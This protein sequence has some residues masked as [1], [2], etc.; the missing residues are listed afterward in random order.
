[1]SDDHLTIGICQGGPLDGQQVSVRSAGFLAVDRQAGK[2]WR[3]QPDSTG[4]VVCTDH[5]DS[6]IYPQGTTTGERAYDPDR[7]W[8]AGEAMDLDI[9]AV[10]PS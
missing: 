10:D 6:L 3:Y 5:D 4:F 9:I 7:A 1:M 8:Q 2:A